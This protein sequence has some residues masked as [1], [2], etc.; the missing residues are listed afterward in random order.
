MIIFRQL[1]FLHGTKVEET[2]SAERF[3]HFMGREEQTRAELWREMA[4][5]R[6]SETDTE[7]E[8][9]WRK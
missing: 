3:T 6:A 1:T 5:G 7:M 2:A 8:Q 4:R 9:G